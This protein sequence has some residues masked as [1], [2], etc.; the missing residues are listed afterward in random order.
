M[1]RRAAAAA[2]AVLVLAGC[3]QEPEG[4]TFDERCAEEGGTVMEDSSSHAISGPITGT[5]TTPQ[6][7]GVGTGYGYGTA[8]ITI[9][10]CI[11]GGDI[12]DMETI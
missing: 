1:S 2:L 4:P 8:T 5:V 7:V 6:G 10:L 9:R 3:S 11:V 12:I